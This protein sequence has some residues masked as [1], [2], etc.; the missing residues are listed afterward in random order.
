MLEYSSS[1]EEE[2]EESGGGQA[3]YERW[4]PTPPSPRAAEEQ[5]PGEGVGAPAAGRSTEEAVRAAEV[6]ARAAE[7][8]GGAMVA[9]SVVA[10]EEE[11]AGLLHRKVGHHSSRH[12]VSRGEFDLFD[13][14]FVGWRRPPPPC[15]CKG[16]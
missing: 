5:A 2:E 10:L 8:S 7:A 1:E 14:A 3:P 9:A 11:E 4:E 12:S 15:T 13:F 16:A 6:P